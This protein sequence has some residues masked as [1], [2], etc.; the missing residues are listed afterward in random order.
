MT[1]A[2]SDTRWTTRTG[3]AFAIRLVREAAGRTFALSVAISVVGAVAIAAQLAL[4]R[5]LVSSV[6]GGAL[7]FG[8][9]LPWLVGLGAA[10][11]VAQICTG[12][13]RDVQFLLVEQLHL[14]TVGKVLDA[15][16]RA[17]LEAFE[18]PTF[19]DALARAGDEAH[20]RSWEVVWG[21]VQVFSSIVT[22]ITVGALVLAVVPLLLPLAALAYVPLALV[23]NRT[24]RALY[25]LSF[26]HTEADRDRD[27]HRRL[28]TSRTDAR[29][30]RAYG[31]LGHLRTR[32][33][34]LANERVDRLR[35]LTSARIR[36]SIPASVFS[37]VV[38]VVAFGI[39]MEWARSGRISLGDAALGIVGLQQ[40]SA[41]FQAMGNQAS[42][43][44]GGSLY[45]RDVATFTADAD[46]SVRPPAV[47]V[48]PERPTVIR[49][50]GVGY[51]YPTGVSDA[52][53][54][55]DLTLRAGEVV[56]I[57][58]HNGSGKTTLARLLLGLYPP[59]SGRIL[60]DDVDLAGCDLAAVRMRTAGVFQDFARFEH[61]AGENIFFGSVARAAEGSAVRDAAA[62][63][64]AA[65]FVEA[66]A[67]GYDTRL[68]TAFDGGTELSGGQWQR[69]A[70]A[71]A[72]YRDA[73]VLVLDEPTAALDPLAEAA[74]FERLGQLAAGRAVLFVSHRF[75]TVRRA[76][77]IVVLDGGRIVES[78]THEE[79]LAHD[80]RYARMYRAQADLALGS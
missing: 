64:G 39:V 53:A 2:G 13:Q 12:L 76:D 25:Q 22:S 11:A 45:L 5:Q 40:L 41:R 65:E 14:H 72:F 29:E 50:E 54:D 69:L 9:L 49:L 68:S 42:S 47:A 44:Y 67:R 4:G 61:T 71:R 10:L 46:A 35:R 27:Y 79:L 23:A 21:V 7:S 28:L 55:V 8:A 57:V 26:D 17:D 3:I 58:G 38:L 63:A 48:P 32:H 80:G 37:A 56:A 31:L 34:R 73:P 16:E 66:L 60:W 51:R 20:E 75:S 59:S 1:D 19:H 77:Q 30:V 33:D 15:A 24:N 43:I 62:A 78:G 36:R 52:L 70:I 6:D 74:L 18:S